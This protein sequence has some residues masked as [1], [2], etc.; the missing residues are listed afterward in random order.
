MEKTMGFPEELLVTSYEAR[1]DDPGFEAFETPEQVVESCGLKET[2]V[3][4]Y[5]LVSVHT[6]RADV[7]LSDPDWIR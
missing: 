6:V 2:E 3:A 5:K 1:P 7:I 4:V